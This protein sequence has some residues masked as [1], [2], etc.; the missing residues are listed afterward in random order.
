MAAVPIAQYTTYNALLTAL[1]PTTNSGQTI[2][3][4]ITN[5]YNTTVTDLATLNTLSATV[6]NP[7][8][9]GVG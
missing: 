1:L 5:S 7:L 9:G 2:A 4:A 6:A 3:T 8:L